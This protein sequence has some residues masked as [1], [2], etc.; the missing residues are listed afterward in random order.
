MTRHRNIADLYRET[1]AGRRS[2]QAEIRALVLA[3]DDLAA[4]LTRLPW[5]YQRPDQ[6]TGHI[7][8]Y[9]V[10]HRSGLIRNDSPQRVRLVAIAH[11]A[12]AR[13]FGE[14][15]GSSWLAAINHDPDWNP[16]HAVDP[17]DS[18]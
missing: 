15:I 4:Q 11:E 14:E 8:P 5:P 2:E 16:H 7:P 1:A 13:K 18:P 3:N 12:I 6:W 9:L 10:E 17:K